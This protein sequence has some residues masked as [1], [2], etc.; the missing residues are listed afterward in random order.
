MTVNPTVHFSDDSLGG[1]EMSGDWLVC[2]VNCSFGGSSVK[3]LLERKTRL[4]CRLQE[5]T[6]QGVGGSPDLD[7]VRGLDRSLLPI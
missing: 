7:G 2:V 4:S 5:V 1:Q 6:L 3:G